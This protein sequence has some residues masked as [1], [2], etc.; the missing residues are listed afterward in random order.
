[1]L[2]LS[3]MSHTVI[4]KWSPQGFW[5]DKIFHPNTNFQLQEKVSSVM[6]SLK[7]FMVPLSLSLSYPEWLMNGGREGGGKFPLIKSVMPIPASMFGKQ[8]VPWAVLHLLKM[9]AEKWGVLLSIHFFSNILTWRNNHFMNCRIN[10]RMSTGN[11]FS[12]WW[13]SCF[14]QNFFHFINCRGRPWNG[15]PD[16]LRS[17]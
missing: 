15:Y 17:F 12:N 6:H 10:W 1:M 11:G 3:L 2:S 8:K 16:C 4:E 7:T 14:L 9:E 5:I 13:L